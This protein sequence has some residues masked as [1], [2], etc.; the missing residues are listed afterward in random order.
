MEDETLGIL[1]LL[2]ESDDT[3]TITTRV[4]IHCLALHLQEEG[5]ETPTYGF[6]G[7]AGGPRSDAVDH[8]LMIATKQNLL[9][10]KKLPQFRASLRERF[11]LTQEG[12]A[13][14]ENH[15]HTP[16]VQAAQTVMRQYDI[17]ASNLIEQTVEEF[18]RFRAAL[19]W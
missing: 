9:V 4:K 17:P 12:A 11:T 16:I 19:R 2:H 6:D 5:D 7:K 8:A 14:V 3:W 13:A 1:A 18:P 15:S 10:V